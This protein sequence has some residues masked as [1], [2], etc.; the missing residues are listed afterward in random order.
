MSRPERTSSRSPSTLM[1][2]LLLVLVITAAAVSGAFTWL[3][4]DG[5]RRWLADRIEA[6]ASTPE[7]RLAIGALDGAVPFA[8]ILTD[9]HLADA[10]GPWLSLDRISYRLAPLALLQGV[11]RFETIRLGRAEVL[12]PPARPIAPAPKREAAPFTLPRLPLGLHIERFAVAEVAL[13]AATPGGPVRLR[14]DGAARLGDPRAGVSLDLVVARTDE[15]PDSF[16]AR[17][18]YLPSQGHLT[19]ALRLEEA[20]GGILAALLG[21]PALPRLSADFRGDGALDDW[22]GTLRIDAGA[23]LRLAAPVSITAEGPGRRVTLDAKGRLGALVGEALRP[24]VDGT[25]SLGASVLVAGDRSL[26]VD[27][28]ELGG[29]FGV[30]SAFG[31]LDLPRDAM[32][33][34]MTFEPAGPDR[35]AGLTGGVSWR[36][37]RWSAVV[38]G[39]VRAPKLA[40]SL[41]GEQVSRGELS[42][43]SLRAVFGAAVAGRLGDPGARID[44]SGRLQLEGPA[45]GS[46]R[47]S[48]LLQPRVGMVVQGSATPSGRIIIDALTLD[49]PIAR[50]SAAGT[51]EGWGGDSAVLAAT[52]E[53][54]DLCRFGKP[55]G[56]SLA[57]AADLHLAAEWDGARTTMRGVAAPRSL[58]TGR[59]GLDGLLGDAPRLWLALSAAR[60]GAV[61][62]EGLALRGGGVQT[63]AS[64][65]VG[66]DVLGIEWM[67]AA[68]DLAAAHPTLEGLL[69]AAGSLTGTPADPALTVRLNLA[70]AGIAGHPVAEVQLDARM[71]DLREGPAGEVALTGSV[72]GLPV[73]AVAGLRMEDAGGVRIDDLALEMASLA[74]AGG[75]TLGRGMA[76]GELSAKVGRLADLAPLIGTTLSGG[77]EADLSLS[78]VDGRQMADAWASAAGL[79]VPGVAS[80]A[81]TV[82]ALRLSDLLREPTFAARLEAEGLRAGDHLTVARGV[83]TAEGGRDALALTLDLDDERIDATG[84]AEVARV[85]GETR[86]GLASLTARYADVRLALAGPARV[87]LAPG[88]L[89]L[90]DLVLQAEGGQISARGRYGEGLDLELALT[91][92]P[93]QLVRLAVPD[94]GMMGSVNGRLRL[95]G[96]RVAPRASGALT[97]HGVTLGALRARALT[98]LEVSAGLDWDGASL[99][100]SSSVSG[101]FGG[102]LL[103]SATL[104]AAPNPATGLPAVDA[105]AGLSGRV[106][107]SARLE[108]LND[109]LAARGDRVGGTLDVDMAFAGSAAAARVRGGLGVTGGSWRA[110]LSGIALDDI[111]L[112]LEGDGERLRV[113]EL[114][115]RS[116]GGGELRGGGNIDIDPLAGFPADLSV[117]FDDAVVID[118]ERVT[119]R[120]RGELE[121][122]GA[123]A[124][125]LDMGGELTV[126]EAQIRL[127]E[128]LPASI[129]T[130]EVVEI[131]VP[132]EV[133]A[134]RP[135]PPGERSGTAPPLPIG[136]DLTIVS[137]GRIFVRGRGLDA[138]VAGRVRVSGGLRAPELSGGFALRRGE[139]NFLGRRFQF[140]EGMVTLPEGGGI[141]ADIRFVARTSLRDAS[142]QITVAG[143]ASAPQILIESSPQ[144]P[145][146]EIL[147]RILFGKR[148]S[149]LSALESIELARSALQL[150]G[151]EAGRDLLGGIRSR[152]G[153]GTLGLGQGEGRQAGS[154]A[155][156]G[157]RIIERVDAALQQG[158]HPGSGRAAVNLELSPNLSVQTEF[159]VNNTGRVGIGMEWEY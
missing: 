145:Q 37:A 23:D 27:R 76:V 156:L 149:S 30:A 82:L 115:A 114:S 49:S 139:L 77:L 110:P 63:W 143:R 10:A 50:L 13:A 132:P 133:A 113:T 105:G 54:P 96:S 12:R 126:V 84:L 89:R 147:A 136:L 122:S 103:A 87:V 44:V 74:A 59:A 19:V 120:V 152:L 135:T 15:A 85:D 93:L 38:T 92:V 16:S 140:D 150:T 100:L 42:A 7:R 159:G 104:A 53:I 127:P 109:L 75:V 90:E 131:N 80:A 98:D 68:A 124:R 112:R 157:R 79:G 34:T 102:P 48:G 95:A 146:D 61:E 141:D 108:V 33:L 153:L 106:W 72:D 1:R 123:L 83:L 78:A 129:Q 111:R 36:A 138:E 142:A 24:L 94:L 71:T 29:A 28:L 134:R 21:L 32:D 35:F 45:L 6:L 151:V 46:E 81:R 14:V 128:R 55:A 57:G 158:L 97:A 11:A 20:D 65:R 4:T 31:R 91:D 67:L 130:L 9:V 5:G 47:I 8:P 86:V 62:L 99:Q 18:R 51:G 22:R 107:G 154:P 101:G 58:S 60:G 117:R 64:G 125:S 2:G 155:S 148:V 116:A 137:P 69:T 52:L 39:P 3:Q 40:M 56:R 118:D 119:A 43:G 73:R 70:R 66:A 25:S 144:L 88:G 17:L 26:R 41:A 121:L